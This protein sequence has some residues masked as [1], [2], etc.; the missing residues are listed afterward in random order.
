MSKC[1]IGLTGKKFHGKDT[2]AGIIAMNNAVMLLSF[3]SPIKKAISIIHEIPEEILSDSKLKETVLPQWGKS[4]RE[5]LQW[6]GTDIYRNQF[7]KDIWLKN[8]EMR[9]RK[10]EDFPIV[11]TD[12]RFDNEAKLIHKLGGSVWRIDASERIKS[13]DKHESENGIDDSLVDLTIYNNG[14]VDE[15]KKIVENEYYIKRQYS[16][17]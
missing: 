15:L 17:Y 12:V 8:M 9:I 14:N 5:L 7:S 2:V 4:P 3:A 6:L 10:Y 1:L 13:D 16:V 11:V